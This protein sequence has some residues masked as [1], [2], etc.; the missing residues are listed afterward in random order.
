MASVCG[1]VEMR[2]G[3]EAS[4]HE[5]SATPQTFQLVVPAPLGRHYSTRG[6]SLRAN[7]CAN[8]PIWKAGLAMPRVGFYLQLFVGLNN[9]PVRARVL[10]SSSAQA[11]K[12]KQR[13]LPIETLDCSKI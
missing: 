4:G 10:R 3:H 6:N 13:A 5:T 12:A 1:R 11:R 2:A 7:R 9:A 8:S